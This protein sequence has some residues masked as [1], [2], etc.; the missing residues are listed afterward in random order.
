MVRGAIGAI[1]DRLRIP[2]IAAPMFLVS[3]PEYVLAACNAGIVG[4]FPANNARTIDQLD[5]WLA[6]IATATGQTGAPW[7]INVMSHRTYERTGE[8]ME[9]VLKH[10]PPIVISALGSPKDLV[11][12]VHSYGGMVFADVN[13]LTYARKAAD[14][15]VDGLV[16]ICSG[17]GGHTGQLSAFAFVP[18]VREFFDGAIVLGG[19]VGSGQAIRAAEI[20]GADFAYLGTRLIAS[21]ESMA[22][23]DYKRMLIE[24][25]ADDIIQSASLTGVAANW[26]KPSLIAAGFDPQQMGPKASIELGR[27][28]HAAAK[29][30]RDVWS[31]GQGV[32]AVRDVESI[33]AIVERLAGEYAA[34]K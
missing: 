13:S 21:C 32:G 20:L 27:P 15:G 11:D 18:A 3:G 1:K 19:A 4:S 30:W 31:A 8:E 14:V 28:E 26:L 7:A 16:L 34:A 23:P 24:A 6:T 10:K 12:A 2:A 29:R 9:L 25:E 5:E 33:S 22:S 17:A